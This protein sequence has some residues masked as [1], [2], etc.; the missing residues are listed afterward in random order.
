MEFIGPFQL[1]S[2]IHPA[3]LYRQHDKK[4]DVTSADL[5]SIEA[6]FPSAASDPLFAEYRARAE[7]STLRRRPGRKPLTIPEFLRLWAVRFAIED[8]M[9]EIWAKRRSGEARR[10]RGDREPYYQAVEIVIERFKL[11]CTPEA[12]VNRLSRLGMS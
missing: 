6:A 7:A 11:Y 3:W 12:L 2:P 8:E 4:R 9:S 10:M 5:D 1:F